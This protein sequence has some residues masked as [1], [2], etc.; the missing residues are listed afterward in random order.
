MRSPPSWR[1]PSSIVSSTPPIVVSSAFPPPSAVPMPGAAVDAMVRLGLR[2]RPLSTEDRVVFANDASSNVDFVDNV[3]ITCVWRVSTLAP[4][5]SLPL[6]YVPSHAHTCPRPPPCL[7]TLFAA[8]ST[9]GGTSCP[10]FFS[11]PLC[12]LLTPTF[13]WCAC[14]SPSLK[15]ASPM[16]C[17]PLPCPWAL[18]SSLTALPQPGRTTSGTWTIRLPTTVKVRGVSCAPGLP[19]RYATPVSFPLFF[20]TASP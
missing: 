13:L 15:S 2:E 8:Q 3:I 20:P 19:P 5:H 11:R 17:P 18:C 14:S 7:P 10:Y 6:C 4:P 16:A 9:S 1:A 12:A